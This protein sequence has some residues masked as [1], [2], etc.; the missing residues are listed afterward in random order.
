MLD[1]TE[2]AD[3]AAVV[4]GPEDDLLEWD[5]VGWR[6]AEQNVRQLS[7][8]PPE[9]PHPAVERLRE[10]EP[11]ELTPRQALELFYELKGLTSG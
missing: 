4:N 1:T 2:V 9:A 7:L 11:D 6:H 3:I 5:A 8:F 10:L